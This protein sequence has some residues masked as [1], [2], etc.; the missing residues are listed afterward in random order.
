MRR[1]FRFHLYPD[2]EQAA[3]IDRQFGTVR[4]VWNK[5]LAVKRH[6]YRVHGEN[7]GFTVRSCPRRTI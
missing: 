4:F 6:R 7:I 3:F 1:A 5:A 2:P